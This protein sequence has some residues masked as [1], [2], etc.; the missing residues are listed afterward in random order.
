MQ[1][2]RWEQIY[3]VPVTADA[4]PGSQVIRCSTFGFEDP[5]FG[6]IELRGDVKECADLTEEG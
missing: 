3:C 2:G 6:F 5:A 4:F 1:C